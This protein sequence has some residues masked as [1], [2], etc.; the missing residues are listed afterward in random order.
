MERRKQIVSNPVLKGVVFDMDGVII[1]SEF[2]HYQAICE[3]MGDEMKES[4]DTFLAKCTGSD[5]KYAMGRLAEFSGIK[6]DENLF[7]EWSKRKANA[8]RRLV[9]EEAH[10]MPGAV[11]LVLSTAERFPIALATGSRRSDVDAVLSF[12][13]GGRLQNLFG[14]IVTSDDVPKT[15]P[16]PATY[17]KAVVG[18]GLKP[19]DCLAIED[20][21]N[22]VASAKG[23][24]L[25]VLGISAIH[26]E[27]KLSQAD[28]CLP[29]L[30][31]ATIDKLIC[32]FEN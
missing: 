22:G 19:G 27:E 9:S 14:S 8:L 21:P 30:E 16:D 3:A 7:Q 17:A 11:D 2:A 26:N 23:A 4:Y 1:E 5:E 15:K 31:N 20:S 28:W 24:G 12:L 18:I 6:Y 25:R 32:L 13:A 29:S 10:P